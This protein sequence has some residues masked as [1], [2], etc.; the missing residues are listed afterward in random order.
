MPRVTLR[1]PGWRPLAVLLAVA[2]ATHFAR[3]RIYEPLIPA[4][5]GDPRPWVLGSG[6]AE[7]ACAAGLA[8]PRTRRAAATASAVLFLGVFPGNVKMAVDAHRRTAPAA[9]RVGS[10]VR[11]PMQAPL[12]WW[13]LRIARGQSGHSRAAGPHADA[14]RSSAAVQGLNPVE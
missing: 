7:L 5:L 13:A 11:L 14:V 10:L 1:A 8:L 2:G 9:L 4:R 3:P 6:A 12:V